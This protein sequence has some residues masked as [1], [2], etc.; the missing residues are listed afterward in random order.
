[1]NRMDRHLKINRIWFPIFLFILVLLYAT[2]WILF[3]YIPYSE[4]K[5]VIQPQIFSLQKEIAQKRV[6]LKKAKK[7]STETPNEKNKNVK[8]RKKNKKL[9]KAKKNKRGK[10]GK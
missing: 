5:D 8:G 1:M 10:K 2:W 7:A 3:I 4:K 9:G 6:N